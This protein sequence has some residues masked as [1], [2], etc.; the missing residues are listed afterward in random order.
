MI[1]DQNKGITNISYNHLNLPTQVTLGG[2]NINYVYDASG[3]KLRKTVQGVTTDYAGNYIYENNTLQFFNH[4]EGYVKKDG[5]AFNYVYQYKDHLGNIRL[6]YADTD[7]NGS[8]NSSTEII[9]ESNYYPF[10]L[11]HKGYN[12]VISANGN[13]LAQK[14]KYN[15]KELNDE[16]S[17]DWYHFGARNYDAALGRWMNLDPLAEKMRRHSPYNYAFN[18]PLRYI[19]PDGMAPEDII[20][21]EKNRNELFNAL[22]ELTSDVLQIDGNGLVT[23]KEEN[24]DSFDKIEGSSLISDLIASKSKILISSGGKNKVNTSKDGIVKGQSVENKK[25]ETITGTGKG[26][27]TVKVTINLNDKTGGI[28][29]FVGGRYRPI[30][31]SL[32]HELIHADINTK[33]KSNQLKNKV[34]LRSFSTNEVLNQNEYDTRVRENKIREEQNFV[35][36]KIGRKS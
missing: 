35:L 29:E 9:E 7:N 1:T 23:I 17:L 11:R 20:L 6:S 13:S 18:N 15:G 4:S 24:V 27:E 2:Q 28:N 10:G 25:G 5:S 19:D 3:V 32:A 12:D 22:Q 33:G 21:G 30:S 16:L 14:F 8:I 31:I 34:G 26:Q 36:R